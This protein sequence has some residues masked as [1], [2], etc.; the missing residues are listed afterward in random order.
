MLNWEA[1]LLPVCSV[2]AVAWMLVSNAR[3]GRDILSYMGIGWFAVLLSR[4]VLLSAA[5]LLRRR[6]RVGYMVAA[7]GA[8]L[9][10]K[11]NR[12]SKLPI[13]QGLKPA[14]LLALGGTAEAV[15]FPKRFMR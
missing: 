2:A 5:L 6:R 13:P 10:L 12:R 1:V 11:M 14:S 8:G 15:P 4:F 9:P 3:I 7:V